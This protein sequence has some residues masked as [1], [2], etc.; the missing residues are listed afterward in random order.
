MAHEFLKSWATRII[1]AVNI[2]S[3]MAY[4]K[5][6]RIRAV[7]YSHKHNSNYRDVALVFQIGFGILQLSTRL[8]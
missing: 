4:S 2:K 5:N 8:G 3:V 7:E 1:Y 6:L